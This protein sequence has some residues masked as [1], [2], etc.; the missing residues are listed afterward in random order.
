[1][2]IKTYHCI[3]LA[4]L[5]LSPTAPK[6]EYINF[7][8]GPWTIERKHGDPIEV[9]DIEFTGK[10][11]IKYTKT[12]G[13]TGYTSLY[14]MT[15]F[16]EL[17]ALV[18]QQ[19]G[20]QIYMPQKHATLAPYQHRKYRT[21]TPTKTKTTNSTPSRRSATSK[22]KTIRNFCKDKWKTNYEM[23]EY[24]INN[25]TQASKN[26]SR[27]SGQILK[28]CTEKW[29]NNFEMIEYCTEKQ[30]AAKKRLGY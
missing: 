5:I 1:M 30:N 29:K 17:N 2:N 18:K 27:Y 13:S 23:V 7:A 22:S 20:I 3:L 11:K 24:C 16:T 6:C 28:N 14:N 9:T 25:Q 8:D 4:S 21:D 15:N 19:T 26:I 10:S 12:D